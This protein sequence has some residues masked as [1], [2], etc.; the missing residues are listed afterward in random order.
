MFKLTIHGK[1]YE[2]LADT[3]ATESSLRSITEDFEMTKDIKT[4]IGVTGTPIKCGVTKLCPV[5]CKDFDVSNIRHQFVIVPDCPVNLA[6]R[7]LLC[8]LGL[9]IVCNDNGLE[10]RKSE[11]VDGLFDLMACHSPSTPESIKNHPVLNGV[12]EQLWSTHKYDVGLIK[13]ATP[14]VVVP[15][16]DY[17]P[18]KRQYP[19]RPDA[20]EGMAPIIEQLLKD[21]IIVPA[22]TSPCNT[23]LFPVKKA[24]GETWRPVHDLR[25]VNEAVFARAPVVP[26]PATILSSVPG[27][28][29]WFSVIDLANAF[30]S[31]PVDPESQNWFA[32][33]FKNKKYK[34]TRCPQGYSESPT[35]YSTSLQETLAGFVFP[36]NSTLIQYIDDLLVCS[37]SEE[38]CTVDT[39][40][41]LH[42]LASQGH[43]ASFTKTPIG[44]KR[45][46]LYRT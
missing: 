38:N 16:S 19:L 22:P 12:P 3:G 9:T 37:T 43:K 27:N 36:R 29:D 7:H 31:V 25:A 6:G 30:F 42:Y 40:A 41:L 17:R 11:V 34:W 18:N 13:D 20:E 45:S 4:C 24:D 32:F 15:K 46:A 21:G 23:P 14:M 2:M 10:L 1:T 35:V 33:T 44:E 8:A 26:N 28:A 39:N 5:E